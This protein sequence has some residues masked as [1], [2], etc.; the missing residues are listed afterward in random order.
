MKVNRLVVLAG[1]RPHETVFERLH[2]KQK[3]HIG[4]WNV[5]HVILRHVSFLFLVSFIAR[6]QE[7]TSQA[8]FGGSQ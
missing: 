2:K 8:S 5:P 4:K 1:A 3:Q 6:V 7:A